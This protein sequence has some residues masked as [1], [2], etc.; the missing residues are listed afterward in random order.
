MRMIFVANDEAT[1]VLQPTE[2][3]LNLPALSIAAQ[4]APVLNRRAAPIAAM[5]TDEVN[6]SLLE[7]LAKWIAIGGAIIYQPARTT[8]QQP[9]LQQLR[10]LLGGEVQLPLLAVFA[11][12]GW[13]PHP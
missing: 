7:S 1:K 11:E 5:G 12:G 13:V 3:A 4:F 9:L 6:S 10:Q 8:I 2:G